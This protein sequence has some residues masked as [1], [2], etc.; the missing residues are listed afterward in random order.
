MEK[1]LK[2]L[3]P[4]IGCIFLAGLLRAES[5][6][7]TNFTVSD[8]GLVITGGLMTSASFSNV[9]VAGQFIAGENTSTNFTN[10]MGLLNFN[11]SA[12]A[13]TPSVNLSDSRGSGGS[14]SGTKAPPPPFFEV[15]PSIKPEL[16]PPVFIKEVIRALPPSFIIPPAIKPVT[17]IQEPVA[18]ELIVVKESLVQEPIPV[19]S[20]FLNISLFLEK[21][22]EMVKT[23]NGVGEQIFSEFLNLFIRYFST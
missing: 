16:M 12:A 14:G 4:L 23:F 13:A 9:G 17:V 20:S 2:I 15:F 3:F 19:P 18:E 11:V 7:S 22:R 6:T 8:S 1:F 21:F 5:L 10:Q